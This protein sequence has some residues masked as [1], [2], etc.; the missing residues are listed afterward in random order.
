MAFYG[1]F[2][3]TQ[4]IAGPGVQF[5]GDRLESIIVG[6]IVWSLSAFIFGEHRW[7]TA[8]R[9]S[10]G[11]LEQIFLS[12][13][14]ATKIFLVR[15]VAKLTTQL[16][17]NASVLM[18]IVV[19]TGEPSFLPAYAAAASAHRHPGRLWVSAGDGFSGVVAQAGATGVVGISPAISLFRPFSTD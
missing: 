4:Y 11:T 18:I 14:G 5:C 19:L 1:L 7:R 6:Y 9:G 10:N 13:F 2:L 15:A 8:T 12:P 3:S 16:F 17:E